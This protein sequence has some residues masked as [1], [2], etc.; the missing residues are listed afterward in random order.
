MC[1]QRKLKPANCSQNKRVCE[2][3]SSL[4]AANSALFQHLGLLFQL[5]RR[6]VH[7]ASLLQQKKNHE[8]LECCV[9]K[10]RNLSEPIFPQIFVFVTLVDGW[11]R[12]RLSKSSGKGR[13]KMVAPKRLGGIWGTWQVRSKLHFLLWSLV[14]TKWH[15]NV[16]ELI[17][18]L[19][20]HLFLREIIGKF[21]TR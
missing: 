9:K 5:V 14:T 21:F 10:M 16:S 6:R 12:Q 19:L 17:V 4:R 1:Q 20:P 15:I 3:A 11:K 7:S 13:R 2:R 8:R 18:W